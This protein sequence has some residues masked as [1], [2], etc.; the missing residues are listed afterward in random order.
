MTFSKLAL[1]STT[2]ALFLNML[3]VAPAQGFTEDIIA[4]RIQNADKNKDGLISREEA[5]SMPRLE[6]NFDAIDTNKD[7]QLSQEE[8]LAFRAKNKK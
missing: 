3:L 8:L 7:N 5:K 6:K 2:S 1:I 4:K